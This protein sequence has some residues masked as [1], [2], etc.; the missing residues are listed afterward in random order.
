MGTVIIALCFV[1]AWGGVLAYFG[2]ATMDET[3]CIAVCS[4]IILLY[5][6][7]LAGKLDWGF[8]FVNFMIITGCILALGKLCLGAKNRE[9]LLYRIKESGCTKGMPALMA[10]VLVWIV[11]VQDRGI[12][13]WDEFSHWG[14]TVKNMWILDKMPYVSESSVTFKSYPPATALFEYYFVRFDD[15]VFKEYTMY[16][17]YNFMAY[18]FLMPVYKLIHRYNIITFFIILVI[19]LVFFRS[20]YTLLLVDSMLGITYCSLI[21]CWYGNDGGR[22]TDIIRAGCICFIYPLMKSSGFGLCL[23]TILYALFSAM[24][25]SENNRKKKVLI[26]V[27]SG[28]VSLVSRLIW[29]LCL[30]YHKVDTS[31]YSLGS[32]QKS[33]KECIKIARHYI[34]EIVWGNNTNEILHFSV[35]VWVI[36]LLSGQIVIFIKTK[37]VSVFFFSIGVAVYAVF[38]CVVY[39]LNMGID[40]ALSL[41][42]YARYISPVILGTFMAEIF[43]ILKNADKI[44]ITGITAAFVFALSIRGMKEGITDIQGKIDKT[45]NIQVQ[46]ENKKAF[47]HIAPEDQV[48]FIAQN[49]F[50]TP[51]NMSIYVNAPVHFTV[52]RSYSLGKPYSESDQVTYPVSYKE[53]ERFLYHNCKYLYIYQADEQFTDRYG[54]LF[55]DKDDIRANTLYCVRKECNSVRLELKQ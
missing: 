41:G 18:S 29:T 28:V 38:L 21:L 1:F 50:G 25:E 37:K 36:L 55:Q 51:Y 2:K 16:Y 33:L 30:K 42:S 32:M 7:G 45:K 52:C 44:W 14:L 5:I 8:Y 19:P 6:S 39:C 47:E 48:C 46:Y 12:C 10:M 35:L 20:Y 22:K 54:S 49:T 13:H 4:I 53:L 27:T 9:T 3:C 40:T 15:H 11:L 26:V 17:A 34:H 43:I 31:F 24:S 23:L